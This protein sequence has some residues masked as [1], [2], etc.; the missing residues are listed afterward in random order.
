[1]ENAAAFL[2][3]SREYLTGHYLPK[4]RAAL[5]PLTEEDLW[6]RPNEASNSIG[7]LLLHLAGNIRQ[8]VVSGVG[9]APDRRDRA[10]EFARR[11]PLTR[12]ELLTTLTEAVLEADAVIAR[13]HPASLGDR[14]PIQGREVTVLQAIYHVVEHL[15]MHAGQIFYI[16]KLRSGQDLG[17][18]RMEGRVPRPAWPGHPSGGGA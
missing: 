18:Y 15:A 8:W 9:G 3:Q 14:R 1:M 5:E 4:L 7:N 11:E 12:A 10:A 16:V 17:F 6:W 13:I 2:A